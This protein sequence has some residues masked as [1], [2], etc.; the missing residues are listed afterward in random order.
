MS[1]LTPY[2]MELDMI[3]AISCCNKCLK[4]AICKLAP[5]STVINSALKSFIEYIINR[6]YYTERKVV[7]IYTVIILQ[8]N[9]TN[10]KQYHKEKQTIV[11][12]KE[13]REKELL[14]HSWNASTEVISPC[15]RSE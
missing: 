8:Y 15:H 2:V 5:P 6:I 10:N 3:V 7:Y 9:K 13:Y 1:N 12:V 11:V 4:F 14:L